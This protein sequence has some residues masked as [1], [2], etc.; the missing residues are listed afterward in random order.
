V[1]GTPFHKSVAVF[2]DYQGTRLTE[3]ID[4][5][6]IAVPSTA[7]RGGD[8]SQIPLTGNVNGNAWAAQLSTLLGKSVSAGEPYT[9]VFPDGQIPQ[10]I[11]SAPA[12]YLLA[13][14][15]KPNAGA[16]LFETAA[17]AETLQDNKGAVRV[18]WTHGKGTL[19]GYYFLDGYSLDNPYPTG[20]GGASVPGFDATSNGLAQLA[21]LGHTMTFGQTALNEFHLS[22]MR[23][24]NS[25][26]QPKGG[27]GPSLTTQ[28]FSN[29]VALKPA[30]IVVGAAGGGV[31][32]YDKSPN[33]A[34]VRFVNCSWKD[35]GTT[36]AGKKDRHPPLLLDIR[37]PEK[38]SSLG[39]VDFQDCHIY[40]SID[41][42]VLVL[43]G[44]KRASARDI[45]GNIAVHSPFA[46][47][48]RF[49]PSVKNVN[50]KLLNIRLP[51]ERE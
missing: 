51:P 22:F 40:D 9:T 13:S 17:E 31:Y 50:L 45:Q 14:I 6:N 30:A 34:R 16:T 49:E 33:S 1:G 20:T 26:G 29:I 27:V 47:R 35:V 3:G 11:W 37:R 15:P 42:P 10:S 7:E 44:K 25:V 39:G 23:N 19:T 4:T 38:A 36:Q 46:A 32:L 18:D 21:S 5:G 24:A 2:A 28:G 12:K 43:E 41:R 8:F 48:T